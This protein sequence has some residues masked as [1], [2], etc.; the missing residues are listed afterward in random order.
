MFD[1]APTE[2]LIVAI[3]ALVVIGPKDLPRFMRT[4]G[5]WVAKARGTARHFRAGIATMVREAEL[6]EMEQKWRAENE[7]IMRDF[8]HGQ[9]TTSDPP[10]G[11]P[12]PAGPA[13][14][15]PADSG[16]DDDAAPPR[17]GRDELP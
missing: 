8:P 10:H 12:G 15:G 6:E 9:P 2:L 14:I 17:P 4:V 16:P 3:V 7:R 5:H 13:P 11:D 1:I